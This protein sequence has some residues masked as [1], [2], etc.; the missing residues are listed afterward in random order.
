VD[1]RPKLEIDAE[2]PLSD[3]R[4]QEIRW[5]GKLA[6]FGQGNPD[7]TLLSRGVTVVDSKE[8]GEEGRHLRLKLRQ[9][10]LVWP[11]IAFGWE[12]DVPAEGSRVDIVYSLSAD[13]FGPSENGGALQLGLL[14]L[15]PSLG[16]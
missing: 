14:D 6:P 15:R 7:V 8:V 13:R 1:L 11:A 3:L 4:S 2:W 16:R 10:N 12:G 5:M 9:G